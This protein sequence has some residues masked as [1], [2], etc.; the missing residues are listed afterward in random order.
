M[1]ELADHWR[2]RRQDVELGGT[3]SHTPITPLH[4]YP[5]YTPSNQTQISRSS[6]LQEG[7]KQSLILLSLVL[8]TKA[9]S[10]L[11]AGAGHSE[12][13]ARSVRQGTE[14]KEG[15]YCGAT[16]STSSP[17]PIILSCRETSYKYANCLHLAAWRKSLAVTMKTRS[18]DGGSRTCSHGLTARMS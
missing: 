6:L 12:F 2:Q 17:V 5:T 16:T 18:E 10:S 1:A 15:G 9:F 8:L 13:E 11:V 4:H 7:S 14:H 3:L